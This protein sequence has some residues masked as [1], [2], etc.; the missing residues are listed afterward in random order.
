MVMSRIFLYGD[1]EKGRCDLKEMAPDTE[2][3]HEG[4]VY[5][6]VLLRSS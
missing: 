6:N 4:E 2:L 1:N 5:T 3:M